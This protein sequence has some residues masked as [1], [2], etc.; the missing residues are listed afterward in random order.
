MR[1]NDTLRNSSPGT[2]SDPLC[3]LCDGK[4]IVTIQR[5]D[6]FNYGSRASAVTLKVDMPVRRCTECDFEFVDHEGELLRHEAVC[7][8]LGV[9]TPT[10]VRGVREQYGMTRAAFAGITGFGEATLTRWENG[11]VVQ[12]R[13]NDRFLRLLTS[14]W[15]MRR[16]ERLSAPKAA[17]PDL[18]GEPHERFQVLELTE[19]IIKRQQRFQLRRAG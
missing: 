10:E 4:P 9:L 14:R 7:R 16:L 3:P 5:T 13:A 8:H 1:T 15:I 11:A 2:P 6:T 12:N 19:S 17:K 18:E